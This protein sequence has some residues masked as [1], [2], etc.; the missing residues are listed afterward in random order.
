M[1][2]VCRKSEYALIAVQQLAR[3]GPGE[4]V[5]VSALAAA[6]DLPADILAKV[7]QAL[8]R[9]GVVR[10]EKGAGGGYA[11]CRPPAQIRFVDVVRPFEDGLAVVACHGGL[12]DC[13]RSEA[14]SLRDPMATVNA[15]VVRQF[16]GL[17]MDLFVPTSA[18]VAPALLP[19]T[20]PLPDR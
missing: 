10:A 11:L 14:C 6:A 18:E 13:G 7:L 9:E 19:S 15:F 2:K 17:T 8:K 1:F 5:S 12:A 4:V 3:A 20:P 16:G